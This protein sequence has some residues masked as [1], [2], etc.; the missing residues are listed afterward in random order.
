MLLA[1][2]QGADRDRALG[3][4][5]RAFATASTLGMAAVAE[6]ILNDLA[7]ATNARAGLDS[8]VAELARA[9]G[10]GSRDRRAAYDGWLELLTVV[11]ELVAAA[12]LAARMRTR[13]GESRPKGARRGGGAAASRTSDIAGADRRPRRSLIACRPAGPVEQWFSQI[14]RPESVRTQ[15]VA[16]AGHPAVSPATNCNPS[17]PSEG[18]NASQNSVRLTYLA[19]T[20]SLAHHIDHVIRHN[21]V[22][23]R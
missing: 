10:L 19:A 15:P 3:L 20:L 4:L 7:R 21:A 5:D 14:A 18:P 23:G 22:G 17:D 1:R 13:M 16:G 6:G 11:S 2:G 12:P 9:V 8:L